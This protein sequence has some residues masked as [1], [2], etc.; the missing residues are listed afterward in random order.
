V[1]TPNSTLNVRSAPNTSSSIVGRVA[2]GSRVTLDCWV[3]GQ[4]VS[5]NW[6][7]TSLWP[8]SSVGYLSDGFVYTGTN[9]PAAGEPQCGTSTPAPASREHRALAW[10]DSGAPGSGT[11]SSCGANRV[12]RASFAWVPEGCTQRRARVS[13]RWRE[14]C[15]GHGQRKAHHVPRPARHGEGRQP[16]ASWQPWQRSP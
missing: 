6:G 11:D 4:T 13:A 14:Q 2:N 12:V 15:G 8:R 5:G 9:G 10:P 3:S 7:A 16:C 1:S